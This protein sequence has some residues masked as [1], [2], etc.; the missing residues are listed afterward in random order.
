MWKSP[1]WLELLNTIELALNSNILRFQYVTGVSLDY[2]R[3]QHL[4]RRSAAL[5]YLVVVARWVG[6]PQ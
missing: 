6:L 2:L 5:G 3:D 4:Q 1:R